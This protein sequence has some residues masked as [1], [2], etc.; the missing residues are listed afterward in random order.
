MI[1]HLFSADALIALLTL[2][3]L[4][5]VLGIDNV[6]FISIVT[7]K[8]PD[9]QRKL[10]LVQIHSWDSLQGEPYRT[11]HRFRRSWKI[12]KEL[13]LAYNRSD[14]HDWCYFLLG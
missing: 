7:G 8:L 12:T 2:T 1:E 5:I 3:F 9:D 13:F 11:Y 4:E 10:P 14:S 6:I